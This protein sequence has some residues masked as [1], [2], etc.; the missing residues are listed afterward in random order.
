MSGCY[1]SSTFDIEQCKID[2]GLAISKHFGEVKI[3]V[4]EKDPD[5]YYIAQKTE[6]LR[7]YIVSDGYLTNMPKKTKITIYV[8][9]NPLDNIFTSLSTVQSSSCKLIKTIVEEIEI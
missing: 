8:Y 3:I 4:F 7:Y 9:K 6:D 5:G 2:G 1:S